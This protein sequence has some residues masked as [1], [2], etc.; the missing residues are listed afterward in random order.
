M[1][2]LWCPNL[3]L[4]TWQSHTN[5]K[6]TKEFQT[7][8]YISVFFTM[9]GIVVVVQKVSFLTLYVIGINFVYFLTSLNLVRKF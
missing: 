4:E 3:R 7:I 6:Q 9:V 8:F 5:L 1:V 2:V